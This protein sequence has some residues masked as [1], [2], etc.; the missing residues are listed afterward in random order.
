MRRWPVLF[1]FFALRMVP[2]TTH[3]EQPGAV[4]IRID[5]SVDGTLSRAL[6]WTR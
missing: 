1:A 5:L 2:S 4:A 6:G 3:V